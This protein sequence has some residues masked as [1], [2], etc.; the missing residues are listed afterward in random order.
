MDKL[1]FNPEHFTQLAMDRLPL[2]IQSLINA[3]GLE[4]WNLIIGQNDHGVQLNRGRW[5]SQDA[6]RVIL[7][8]LCNMVKPPQTKATLLTSFLASSSSEISKNLWNDK[9]IHLGCGHDHVYHLLNLGLQN[10]MKDFIVINFDA[11]ADMRKDLTLHSGTPFRCFFEQHKKSIGSYH[12]TQIGLS[13]FYQNHADLNL[14]G[15]QVNILWEDELNLESVKKTLSQIKNI[16][17]SKKTMLIV[18]I[19]ADVL[20]H[21]TM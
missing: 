12:L 17:C 7:K 6:G 14:T 20:Q 11:H 15:A 10:S 4:N 21:S 8:Q 13:K 19:D 5:G 3:Q 1:K 2:T 9:L 18:S 16:P